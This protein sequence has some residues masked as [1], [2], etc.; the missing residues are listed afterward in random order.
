MKYSDK[1]NQ[2]LINDLYIT[3]ST[4]STNKSAIQPNNQHTT[5]NHHLSILDYIYKNI[6]CTELVR[7]THIGRSSLNN[8][9]CRLIQTDN[10]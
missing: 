5:I 1:Q 7:F 8:D 4:I 10:L 3:L 9:N 2:Y 6:N